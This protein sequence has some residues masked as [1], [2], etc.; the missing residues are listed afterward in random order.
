MQLVLRWE[1]SASPLPPLQ[2]REHLRH[3]D[4]GDHEKRTIR[5]TRERK[6]HRAALQT[7][8][9]AFL[10]SSDGDHDSGSVV[11]N[12]EGHASPSQ[13]PGGKD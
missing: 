4:Q 9:G 1:L 12:S 6:G 13:S 2:M 11:T 3:G 10:V 7:T 8:H 5:G